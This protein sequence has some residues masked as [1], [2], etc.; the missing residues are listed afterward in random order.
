[1]KQEYLKNPTLH[2]ILKYLSIRIVLG[3]GSK[4]GCGAGLKNPNSLWKHEHQHNKTLSLDFKTNQKNN[5]LRHQEECERRKKLQDF[6]SIVYFFFVF[7]LANHTYVK[8]V[9]NQRYL[10]QQITYRS[11]EKTFTKKNVLQATNAIRPSQGKKNLNS[12]KSRIHEE[13]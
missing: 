10:N 2:S 5:L 12:N 3:I 9:R 8:N 13:F 7:K 6:L 11:N 1:M 4:D